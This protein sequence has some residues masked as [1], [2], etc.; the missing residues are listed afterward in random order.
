MSASLLIIDP[1]NDFCDIPGAALP[2]VGANEDM[3][4]LAR[5]MRAAE[6]RLDD[7]I[8]TLDSHP[9]VA[10]ERTS[11][12]KSGEGAAVSPFTR[13]TEAEVRA[14]R[15]L[16]RD[17]AQM[18]AVLAYLHA[19]ESGGRYR[20]MVW[21]VHC[22][23]GTWGHNIH[24]AVAEHLA[25][26]EAHRQRGS[27]K[28]LKGLNP[29][30][31]QYSA[32]RA[33]VPRED[34][35]QTRTNAT[36]VNRAIPRAGML[37]VAGEAASHCVAATMADLFAAMQPEELRRVVLLRDCMSPVPGFEA[38]AEKFFAQAKALGAHVTTSN[39]V[40]PQLI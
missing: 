38:D 35:E 8:V 18:A 27:L 11:F 2:V 33:E 15:Y 36:L 30:T 22:V 5:F 1:Q 13:I 28:V 9:S 12:W 20:L 37:I 32:V 21:P 19:L 4:R 10:I 25:N 24:T 7:V 14:G 39:E 17:H 31:E 23:L 40:L 3:L 16:P 6:P 29:L 34:D 26:W